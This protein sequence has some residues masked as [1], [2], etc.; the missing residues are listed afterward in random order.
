MPSLLHKYPV[1]ILEAHVD[2][3]GHVNNAT[4][5]SLFEEARWDLITKNGYGFNTVQSL[6]QGPVILELSM[7]FL[8]E[9]RLREKIT[10]ITEMISYENKVGRLRQ[11]M[12]KESGQDACVAE[13]VFGLLDMRTRKLI[14]P[15]EAWRRA[16]NPILD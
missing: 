14:E 11:T 9:L 10:I 12:K 15:T 3:L 4:Y 6:Q 16:T 2:S 5:L 7:K 8:Q 1:L 13:M